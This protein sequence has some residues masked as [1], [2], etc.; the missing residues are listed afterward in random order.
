MNIGRSFQFKWYHLALGL[1][2]LF[3]VGFVLLWLFMGERR[4]SYF[5][6]DQTDLVE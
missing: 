1:L 2:G 4:L 3:A 6:E 5:T